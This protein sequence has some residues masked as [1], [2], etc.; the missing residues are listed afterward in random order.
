MTAKYQ[1]KYLNLRGKGEP[2]RLML[3]YLQI[4]FYDDQE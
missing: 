3:N 4:A 1:L 2:I